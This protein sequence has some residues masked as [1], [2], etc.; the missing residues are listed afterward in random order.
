MEQPEERDEAGRDSEERPRREEHPLDHRLRV[1]HGAPHLPPGAEIVVS[2][3]VGERRVDAR[4]SD[5][6]ALDLRVG[7]PFASEEV[8][9]EAGA[10]IDDRPDQEG[11]DRTVAEFRSLLGLL[12]PEALAAAL[13][14]MTE[15]P[16]TAAR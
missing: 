6:I 7:A 15:E 8:L 5:G 10:V 2:G 3:P 16:G 13:I 9:P 14:D 12:D 1:G 4:P 11:I